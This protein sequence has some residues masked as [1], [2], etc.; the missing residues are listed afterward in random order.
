MFSLPTGRNLVVGFVIGI[1]VGGRPRQPFQDNLFDA[2]PGLF[3]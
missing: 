1:L 3:P 2:V